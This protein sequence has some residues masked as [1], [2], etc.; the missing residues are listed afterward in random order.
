MTNTDWLIQEFESRRSRLR[1]VATR[2]LGSSDEAEDALQETWIRLNRSDAAAIDNLG[3]WL[4]TV[5]GRVCLDMLRARKSRR[6]DSLDADDAAD[7]AADPLDSEAELILA[8][9][10][11]PV[12]VSVLDTLTP[13]ERVAF[14]LHDMFDLSFD[15]IAPIV[16]RSAAAARQLA[17]RARR[18]V[19]AIG[20]A[21]P[22]DTSR[23]REIVTAF[24]AASRDG[25]F[26]ALMRLLDPNVRLKADAV[27]VKTA[28]ANRGRPGAFELAPEIVGAPAVAKLFSGRAQRA[29]IV[30][31]NGRLAAAWAPGGVIRSVFLATVTDGRI[32]GIDLVMDPA[33]LATFDIT[34]ANE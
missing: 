32:S 8:D 9:S 27:A 26:D 19:R 34:P 6:E 14:V 18:R 20:V 22:P 7:A 33:R 12:L 5:V 13:A 25:D 16:E 29:Q 21:S 30:R 11:G 3:G 4:T 28:E 2:M 17:S 10:I 23:Q 31:V 24:L 1:A 15:E